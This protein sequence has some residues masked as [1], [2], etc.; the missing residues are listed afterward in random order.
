MSSLPCKFSAAGLHRL[1]FIVFW[2]NQSF[3]HFIVAV[4]MY[5]GDNIVVS[6]GK[7]EFAGLD[8]LSVF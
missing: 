2:G 6:G 1:I 5:A 8:V 3:L 4:W 7:L